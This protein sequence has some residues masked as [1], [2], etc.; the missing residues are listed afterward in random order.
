MCIVVCI[1][2]FLCRTFGDWQE[3][4]FLLYNALHHCSPCDPSAEEVTSFPPG[5]MKSSLVGTRRP[6][7]LDSRVQPWE[8]NDRKSPGNGKKK[9]VT[10]K[11][12]SK[13]CSY[14]P[15]RTWMDNMVAYPHFPYRRQCWKKKNTTRTVTTNALKTVIACLLIP[16]SGKKPL[17]RCTIHK[18][19]KAFLQP[20]TPASVHS[21]ISH[22]Q[23]IT[24]SL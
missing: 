19:L 6:F 21:D 7:R 22:Q 2:C 24:K 8:I 1:I 14:T 20:P 3:T 11:C 18:K 23:E 9:S 15:L 4:G 17:L 13:R 12:P 5:T 16:Q 10:A